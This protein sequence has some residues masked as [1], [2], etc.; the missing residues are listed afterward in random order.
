MTY[1]PKVYL[2]DGGDKQVVASGGTVD[3]EAGSNLELSGSAIPSALTFAPAAGGANVSEVTITVVD[4]AG[5]TLAGQWPI[6][7]WLSDDAGGGGLTG[8]TASGTVQVKSSE[9]ADLSILTA[10]K[11]LTAVTKAAGTY[12][13]EITDTAKTQFYVAAAVTGS[14]ALGVSAQLQTADYGS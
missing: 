12:V 13:L 4:N 11:H 5:N 1:Q 2:T 9:G 3:F 6:A 8:T 7:V 14:L 10:K